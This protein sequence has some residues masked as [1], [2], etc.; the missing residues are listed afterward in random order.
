MKRKY[1][2]PFDTDEERDRIRRWTGMTRGS[3]L[4]LKTA[5]WD[6]FDNAFEWQAGWFE[7]YVVTVTSP[8][9]EMLLK[10]QFARARRYFEQG[11]G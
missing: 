7:G 11:N 6:S 5:L 8:K 2:I 10:L 4:T 1:F 3:T 9:A